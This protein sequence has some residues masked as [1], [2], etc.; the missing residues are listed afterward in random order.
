MAVQYSCDQ[1]FIF[2][3]SIEN[4]MGVEHMD[5]VRGDHF[6]SLPVRK[7]MP[8]DPFKSPLKVGRIALGALC[9]ETSRAVGQYAPKVA[10]RRA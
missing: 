2:S 10:F 9:S 4:E 7:R 5:A 1:Y 3:H 8:L 6:G